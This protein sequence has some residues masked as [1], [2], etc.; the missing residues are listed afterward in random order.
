MQLG[1]PQ[2][3]LEEERIA[4]MRYRGQGHEV[5]VPVPAEAFAPG[6]EEPLRAAFEAVYRALYGR[7]IPRLEVEAVSWVLSLGERRSLPPR[8]PS[9]DA[10]PEPSAAATR[11]VVDPGTGKAATAR[12]FP[13]DRLR[14][15]EPCV[16]PAII[17]EAE[18]S[19][20]VPDG[21][22][23]ALNRSGHI[24]IDRRAS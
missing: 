11:Q 14:P 16:G 21:F 15:G 13:R 10:L 12:V 17:T 9:P 4:Y 18:T 8:V 1:A 5:R 20:L 24:V 23:A 2:V 22:V 3:A 7:I 6:G 19:T